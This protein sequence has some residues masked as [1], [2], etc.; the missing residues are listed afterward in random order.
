MNNAF[1][2]S[3]WLLETG[4]VMLALAA[5]VPLLRAILGAVVLVASMAFRPKSRRLAQVGMAILPAFLR[6]LA[7][8]ALGV[9]A[10]GAPAFADA[11]IVVDRIVHVQVDSE[12]PAAER[13]SAQT[14]EVQP[15]DSLWGIARKLLEE[16]APSP[17]NSEIDRTWR[18]L[19]KANLPVV[20]SDPSLLRPGQVLKVTLDDE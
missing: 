13:T 16:S 19:W 7:G 12:K 20:G 15:G 17:T 5:A 6:S 9:S 11:S 8:A 14:Y 2:T 4:L 1:N 18:A 10:L 3:A